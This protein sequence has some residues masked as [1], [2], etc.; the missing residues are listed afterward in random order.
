MTD[1]DTL[2]RIARQMC[3]IEGRDYDRKGCKRAHWRAKARRVLA[4]REQSR[5]PDLLTNL[6]RALGWQ[7]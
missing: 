6:M 3:E 2:E 7:V 5:T 4:V 1:H